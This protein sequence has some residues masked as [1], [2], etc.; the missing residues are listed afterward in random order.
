MYD[1]Q[2]HTWK[3]RHGY[4]RAN[5]EDNIPIIEAKMTD[6]RVLFYYIFIKLIVLLVILFLFSFAN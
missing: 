1:E 6:G 5:D 4:D 3:R 2:T